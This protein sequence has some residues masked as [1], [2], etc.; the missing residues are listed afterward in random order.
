[1]LGRFIESDFIYG[2]RDI[3]FQYCRWVRLTKHLPSGRR[4]NG[5]ECE[6][7]RQATHDF[8][9]GLSYSMGGWINGY[10]IFYEKYC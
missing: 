9:N 2:F 6:Y 5:R 7:I 10:V 1:M 8:F 3:Y 4:M